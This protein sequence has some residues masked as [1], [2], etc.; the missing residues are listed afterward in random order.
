[1]HTEVC[2][3]CKGTGRIPDDKVSKQTLQFPPPK[4]LPMT[5]TCPHCVGDGYIEVYD[6]AG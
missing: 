5:K 2:P 4:P 6:E 1:M 3:I